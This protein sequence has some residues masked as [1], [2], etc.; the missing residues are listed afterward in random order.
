[1]IKFKTLKLKRKPNQYLVAPEGLCEIAK[2][3]R[4]SPVYKV[5]AEKLQ[6]AWEE[7][8]AGQQR[9]ALQ[10]SDAG[11]MTFEYVQRSKLM[12]FPDYITVQFIDLPD[13]SSSTLAIYSRSRY[14]YRDFGVNRNRIENWLHLLENYVQK[15][16]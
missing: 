8:I 14:G 5:S 9:T 6:Q 1:M 15:P 11:E 13:Q 4:S 3:H 16:H 10:K 7:M 12:R 2:P